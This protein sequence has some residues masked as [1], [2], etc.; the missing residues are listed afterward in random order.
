MLSSTVW[1]KKVSVGGCSDG[2]VKLKHVYAKDLRRHEYS[3]RFETTEKPATGVSTRKIPTVLR[4]HTQNWNYSYLPYLKIIARIQIYIQWHLKV[5]KTTA[6]YCIH[7]MQIF[8]ML[9]YCHL[10]SQTCAVLY[11]AISLIWRAV[12]RTLGGMTRTRWVGG[13]WSQN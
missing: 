12:G 7:H 11:N 8:T 13:G 1:N 4:V 9:I 6:I 10:L 2:I 3:N 5:L